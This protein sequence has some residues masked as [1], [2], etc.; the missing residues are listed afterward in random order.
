MGL[1]KRLVVLGIVLCMAAVMPS[2][3][4]HAQTGTIVDEG[5]QTNLSGGLTG[6]QAVTLRDR[7]DFSEIVSVLRGYPNRGLGSWKSCTSLASSNCIGVETIEFN[8]LLPQC[9]SPSEVNCISEFGVISVTGTKIAAELQRKF[10]ATAYNAYSKDVERSLPE[11]GPG[12]LWV[13]PSS[14]GLTDSLHYVRASIQ[15]AA[16]P[17][18]KFSFTG[19]TA[20]ITP[21]EMRLRQCT[22]TTALV[23]DN[24]CTPGDYVQSG[25][26]SGAIDN[27]GESDSSD[28]VMTGNVDRATSKVECAHRKP[29]STN[30]KYYLTVRLSQSPQGWLHGRLAEPNITITET[31]G[32]I[33]LAMTGKPLH[34]PVVHKEMPF[35]DLPD[36]L[37]QKYSK[38]GGWPSSVGGSGSVTGYGTDI[39]AND[40]TKRNRNSIPTSYGPDGIEELKAWMPVLN[41]TSTAD[42]STW[43][44]RTLSQWERGRANSCLTDKTRVTGI[45]V[46]NA[47]QYKAGAPELNANTQA[48]EYQVAAPHRMSS[49]DIFRGLY[50]L[51]MR[52][53]VARCIYKFTDAPIQATVEVIEENGATSTA[54]TSVSEANGWL[55]LTAS[56]FTHSAPTIRATLKQA[57]PEAAGPSDTSSNTSA[58]PAVKVATKSPAVK[59]SRMKVKAS[60]AT[61]TV[62]SRAGLKVAKGSRVA[63]S[64]ARASRKVCAIRGSQLRAT[65]KG[66]CTVSVSVI[67]G[68]KKT[69]RTLRITVR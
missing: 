16:T 36:A 6:R 54:V 33:E 13:V 59:T 64:V 68:K 25:G 1:L 52:S 18:A 24:P 26:F 4:G 32:G 28:C 67:K 34:V 47:T 9:A 17:G 43:S 12:S 48:L 42:R 15:G 69:T 46:T 60:L 22:E 51:I 53:D 31:S 2:V 5:W 30:T 63:V 50:E 41:D 40:G 55:K 10:P 49:G 37:K 21:V 27:Y 19:F 14:A 8:A 29:A 20:D 11:G 7:P 58:T 23:N 66:T 45:V 39:D 62:A 61:K 35:A 38:N 3:A 65:K 44:V 56:G 57:S